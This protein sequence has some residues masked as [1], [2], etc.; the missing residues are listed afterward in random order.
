MD[1]YKYKN[2]DYIAH[3]TNG[4]SCLNILNSKELWLTPKRNTSDFFEYYQGTK[5]HVALHSTLPNSS[6]GPFDK[7]A[8]KASYEIATVYRCIRQTSFCRT[9]QPKKSDICKHMD[10]DGC[11]FV[12]PRMWEQYTSNYEGFCLIFSLSELKKSNPLI[13]FNNVRYRSLLQLD[14]KCRDDSFDADFFNKD[15]NYL[16]RAKSEAVIRSL[17]KAKD[18]RDENEI[19]AIAIAENEEIKHLNL[20]ISEALKAIAFYP[21]YSKK[22]SKNPTT[23]DLIQNSVCELANTIGVEVILM[24]D[25]N[26][27]HVHTLQE[28]RDRLNDVRA[29]LM[30]IINDN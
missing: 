7:R 1:Y 27:F 4:E 24:D 6:D 15:N 14:Q 8:W 3:Y 29:A 9:R 11:C 17:F 12:H 28:K 26:G 18:Y 22:K 2:K 30:E 23:L 16:T 25:E 20:D 21:V 13:R 5:M 19:R 10:L